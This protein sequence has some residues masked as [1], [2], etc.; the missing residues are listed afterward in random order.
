MGSLSEIIVLFL[1]APVKNKLGE[2]QGP[3]AKVVMAFGAERECVS[4]LAASGGQVASDQVGAL[5][6]AHGSR[7]VAA[8]VGLAEGSAAIVTVLA[9]P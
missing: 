2:L 3:Q 1:C 9:L 6:L 5:E 7:P 8:L 4:H